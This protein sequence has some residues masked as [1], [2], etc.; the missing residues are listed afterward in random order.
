MDL[1]SAAV[2]RVNYDSP[3]SLRNAVKGHDVLVSILGKVAL[4]L[5]PRLIDAAVAAG[6]PCIIPS[7]FGGD[8]EDLETRKFP[9][10][11][12]KVLVE[13]RLKRLRG[14]TG[15]SYSFIYNGVLLD[16]GLSGA[17]VMILSPADRTVP[18]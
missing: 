15:V 2:V 6:V 17:G 14:D 12:S 5:Q 8:L 4:Q 7:E 1:T 10:Y 9:T 16:F 11:R 13:E 3:E 18:L